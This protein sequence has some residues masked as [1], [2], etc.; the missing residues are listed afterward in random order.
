M[1]VLIRKLIHNPAPDAR[2]IN[3][4][5]AAS[6]VPLRSDFDEIQWLHCHAAVAK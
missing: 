1:P 4:S 6:V 3:S 5:A 2:G